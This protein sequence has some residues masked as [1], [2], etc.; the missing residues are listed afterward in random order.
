MRTR[1]TTTIKMM[2]VLAKRE[3][4]V[5]SETEKSHKRVEIRP[6]LIH[7]GWLS[8]H[9]T[10]IVLLQHESV[11]CLLPDMFSDASCTMMGMKS[12]ST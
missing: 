10:Q 5:A 3:E 7:L 6:R 4:K 8:F 11:A 12:E 2:N 9:G 1:A